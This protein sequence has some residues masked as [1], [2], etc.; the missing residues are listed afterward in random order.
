MVIETH[1]IKLGTLD[2]TVDCAG[3]DDGVHVLLLHGFPQIRYMWRQQLAALADAG[4]RAI[5][6][7]QRG[8]SAGAR[9]SLQHAYATGLIVAD[10]IALM[11]AIGAERFH[12]IGHDWGGQIAWLLAAAQPQ[13]L[14]SL[15]ILSRP[16]PAAFARA[17]QEDPSQA[18][19]SR[20]HRAFREPDTS[21]RLRAS[22]LAPLREAMIDQGIAAADVEIHLD[23]LMAPGAI[24]AAINWYCAGTIATVEV[25][26]IAA[27]TLYVWGT[28][29]AT[30][31]RYAA[32]LTAAYMRGSYRFVAHEGAG[33]FLVD[34]C[35]QAMSAL[36]LQHLHAHG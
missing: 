7:D 16:H 11:D 23:A 22:A 3:P 21:A 29:D 30:V 24:E 32:E 13:R 31:G 19:R 26:A 36:L 9:P 8:Y 5:A 4:Y 6:P 20:H 25:P 34:Q 10:A 2:F 12:L 27:P 28:Q 33:H 18:E 35:P 14:R 15:S 17:L 1:T